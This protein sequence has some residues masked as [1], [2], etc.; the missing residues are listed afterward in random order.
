MPNTKTPVPA[1]K[2]RRAPLVMVVDD[3]PGNVQ[4]M[5]TLLIENNYDVL[6]ATSGAQALERCMARKPDLAIF[7]LRMPGMDGVALCRRFRE[8]PELAAIPIIF[9]TGTTEE[10]DLVRCFQAGAVDFL[11]KPIRALELLQRVRTHLELKFS[12]DHLVH[13]VR[14][15]DDL[16]AMVAHDL[17]SPL[18]SIRFSVQM[19]AEDPELANPRT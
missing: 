5:G 1:G 8:N 19:L 11:I 7:D 3:E 17:K 18:A 2:Q 9:V 12:R 13:K 6:P 10:E 14:D 15:C 4:Y 16:T